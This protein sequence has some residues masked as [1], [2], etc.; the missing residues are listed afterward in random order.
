MQTKGCNETTKQDESNIIYKINY[1]NCSQHYTGQSGHPLHLRLHVNTN[2][3]LNVTHDI[4]SLIS[5]HVDNNY[6]HEL[7]LDNVEM[8]KGERK[9][10]EYDRIPRSLA[11]SSA[12]HKVERSR[13]GT[14]NRKIYAISQ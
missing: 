2:W 10:K 9:H 12:S 4:S 11:F 7:N 1:N 13:K 14:A 6:S 5:I 8:L 3:L